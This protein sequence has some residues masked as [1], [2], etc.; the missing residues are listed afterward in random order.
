MAASP[1]ALPR[2]SPASQALA[3]TTR[4]PASACTSC[5]RNGITGSGPKETFF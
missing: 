2:H 3:R 5:V 4:R 1:R